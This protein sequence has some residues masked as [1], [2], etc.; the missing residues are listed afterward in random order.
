MFIEDDDYILVDIDEV[1]LRFENAEG[2][3]KELGTMF[4][5]KYKELPNICDDFDIIYKD[6]LDYLKNSDKT[7]YQRHKKRLNYGSPKTINN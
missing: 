2:I 1:F 4:R 6:I 5:N 7:N 3:N